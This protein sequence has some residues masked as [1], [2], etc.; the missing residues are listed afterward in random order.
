M[1]KKIA[2]LLMI[3]F[4]CVSVFAGC[5]LFDTNNYASLKSI[6]ATSGDIEITREQ[7]ITAYNS[8]GYYYSQYYGYSQEKALEKT[9]SDLIDRQNLLNYVD[10]LSEKDNRYKLTEAEEYATIKETWS[11]VDSNLKEYIKKVKKDLKLNSEELA[12]DEEE[13]KDSEYQAK[14]IYSQKFELDDN[15]RIIQKA[16]SNNSYVPSTYSLYNYNYKTRI[17]SSN[18]DYST[19]VWNRYI[20]DLKISQSKLG[21]KDLSDDVVFKRELDRIHKTNIENAKLK[22]YQEIYESTFGLEYDSKNDIYFVKT[23]T[24]NLI[25]DKYT[26]IY[27]SNKE[28]YNLSYNKNNILDLEDDL[29]LFYNT[30]TNSTSRKDYFY[31]GSPTDEEKLLTCVHILVKF[32]QDQLDDI[33]EHKNDPLLQGNLDA[34][35]AQ[36]KS[37]E[38]TFATERNEDGYEIA[39][40]KI[41]VKDL[42]QALLK[43]IDEEI[44]VTPSNELYLEK[45][46]EIFD[47]YIY[48]YNQDSGIINAKFDYVV[49]TKTSAMVKSFTEVVRK[50]YNNGEANY[51]AVSYKAEYDENVTINFPNGV[52]YAGA[53]SEPFLEEASNYTGYHIVLFTGVLKNTV[54]ETLDVSNVFEKLGNVKTS[55]GYG[56]NLFEYVYDMIASSDYSTH[57]SNI[58][59]TVRKDI[60]LNKNNYSD[61]Y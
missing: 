9:I 33:S 39:D 23:E 26:S 1:K 31:Y 22:K 56:Q 25:I 29:N 54:A 8:S 60:C 2:T 20:T 48:K 49:G 46:V 13:T 28:L 16:K 10:D 51:N 61:M 6:V 5:N 55:I 30:V 43:E 38:N 47:K 19:L 58:L 59:N 21:Y 3:L 11:Y 12:L 42:Y 41:S 50:L 45:V 4:I 18:E 35:L 34:V 44:N 7:L 40:N 24:L 37:Q 15:G 17:D 52:G 14:E 27:D 36:D 57:Q 32:S 53:I